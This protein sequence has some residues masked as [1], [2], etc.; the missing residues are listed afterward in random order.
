MSNVWN[1]SG[2]F[3]N[4]KNSNQDLENWDVRNIKYMTDMFKNSGMTKLPSWYKE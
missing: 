1:M 4:A 2:M 3:E